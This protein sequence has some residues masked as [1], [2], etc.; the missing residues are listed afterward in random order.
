MDLPGRLVVSPL[1]AP[2][3]TIDEDLDVCD[4]LGGMAYGLTRLKL[5]ETPTLS[6]RQQERLEGR[7][8]YVHHSRLFTL[9]DPARWP[10]ERDQIRRSL[11]LAQRVR[12]EVVMAVTGP[13]APEMTWEDAASAFTEAITPALE[14]AREAG[15]RICVE[16]T[17]GLR[18]DIS[19]VS[20]LADLAELAEL[21]GIGL[22]ADMFWSWRE[23]DL[24][25]AV[26][27]CAPHLGLVQLADYV[28]GSMSMPDR[29]VPGDG[30]VPFPS[31]LACLLDAGYQSDWDMEL[32]GPRITA[33]GAESVY[34]RAAS[35]LTLA[36]DDV[37]RTR[38][39]RPRSAE[40]AT[41]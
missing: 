26:R 28:P 31:V 25:G 37:Q 27:R 30:I 41:S 10:Q 4:A 16:Q 5:D 23:R 6:P 14:D 17:N 13:A 36:F 7:V 3:A 12:S 38:A 29:A 21:S 19:F 22:C 35:Y 8:G 18:Q 24:A 2:R 15:V 40:H 11:D 20:S 32:L 1:A 33:E 9:A 34:R 39:R